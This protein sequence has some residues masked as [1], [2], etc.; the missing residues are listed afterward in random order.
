MKQDNYYKKELYA[1]VIK[2]AICAC[3][4][5]EK[6][7]QPNIEDKILKRLYENG[8]S[9]IIYENGIFKNMYEN[10]QSQLKKNLPKSQYDKLIGPKQKDKKQLLFDS[11]DKYYSQ[12]DKKDFEEALKILKTELP[13]ISESETIEMLDRLV[14]N[15]QFSYFDVMLNLPSNYIVTRNMM[16]KTLASQIDIESEIAKNFSDIYDTILPLIK[17]GCSRECDKGRVLPE[18]IYNNKKEKERI[19]YDI[20]EELKE[21]TL[22]YQYFKELSAFYREI[23]E[24]HKTENKSFDMQSVTIYGK[25]TSNKIQLKSPMTIN[26]FNYELRNNLKLG[27]FPNYKETGI[28]ANMLSKA[29]DHYKKIAVRAIAEVLNKHGFFRELSNTSNTYN[30]KN[31]DGKDYKLTNYV[32]L[33][34]YEIARRLKI[35][36]HPEAN[37]CRLFEDNATGDK[38]DLIKQLLKNNSNQTGDIDYKNLIT[39]TEIYY[40][41]TFSDDYK[42]NMKKQKRNKNKHLK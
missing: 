25:K 17:Q 35:A 19:A 15:S 7:V 16:E 2:I 24:F 42:N 36:E 39:K 10:I 14:N 28:R 37:R 9:K 23:N 27:L 30:I 40:V 38:N 32:T 12:N 22:Y 34:I 21:I 26:I 13:H 41:K 29:S 11:I 5:M 18:S 6:Q 4:A 1:L 3:E 8:S 33:I 31:K 20:A